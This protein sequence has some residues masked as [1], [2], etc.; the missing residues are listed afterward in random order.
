MF[1]P[2]EQIGISADVTHLWHLG[3]E[4][5]SSGLCVLQATE[6]SSSWPLG[7]STSGATRARAQ[8]RLLYFH[9]HVHG[10]V[11]PVAKKQKQPKCP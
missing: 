4:A 1:E 2:K 3:P 10:S 7:Q 5:P 9:V 6:T 8:Y 11:V